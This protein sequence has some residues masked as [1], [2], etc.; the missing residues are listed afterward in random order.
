MGR[1]GGARVEGGTCAPPSALGRRGDAGSWARKV[2]TDTLAQ[3]G[4]EV[5]I[6]A[7]LQGVSRQHTGHRQSFSSFEANYPWERVWSDEACSL[8]LVE[9][10]LEK[11]GFFS[12]PD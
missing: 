8:S 10:Y 3:R 4:G 7:A 12:S 2:P 9:Y 5:E 11:A 1:A 6:Q